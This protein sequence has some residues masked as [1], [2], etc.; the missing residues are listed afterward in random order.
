MSHC[1]YLDVS[2]L[3][4][5]VGQSAV[6]WQRGACLKFPDQVLSFPWSQGA[7][8]KNYERASFFLA[9]LRQRRIEMSADMHSLKAILGIGERVAA[10]EEFPT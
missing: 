6:P 5:A 8:Q 4:H 2:E 10:S 3:S 9:S 1:P 7:N